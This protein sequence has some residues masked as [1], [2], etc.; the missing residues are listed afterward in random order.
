MV[1]ANFNTKLHRT[2]VKIILLGIIS[3]GCSCRDDDQTWSTVKPRWRD[4][5]S[6]SERE[7]EA[8]EAIALV[9]L[10]R[11]FDDRSFPLSRGIG[12]GTGNQSGLFKTFKNWTHYKH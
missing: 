12:G 7:V 1:Y 11:L 6:S 5:V 9:A 8:G 4:C 3:K 10:P 2:P